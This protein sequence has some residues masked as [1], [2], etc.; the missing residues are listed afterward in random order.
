MPSMN[1]QPFSR[2]LVAES[3]V[4]L[5]GERRAK[6]LP[7]RIG[8]LPWVVDRNWLTI[9][10][11]STFRFDKSSTIN[12]VALEPVL[13]RPLHVGPTGKHENVML[14]DF[15]PLRLKVDFSV[16]GHI[17]N[18]P[19]PSGTASA[20]QQPRVV[21]IGLGERRLP[22][23]V[24][25]DKPGKIPLRPPYTRMLHGRDLDFALQ[26]CHDGSVHHFRHPADFD[27]S[28]YQCAIPELQYE[29]DEISSIRLEGLMPDPEVKM[30]LALPTYTPRALVTYRQANVQRGDV[31]FFL[32]TV[33][34]DLDESSVHVVWRGLAETAAN[35]YHDVDRIH[36]GWAPQSRWEADLRGCWDD[37]LRELPRGRF[38]WAV[39]RKD[40]LSDEPP[41]PLAE[42]E[43]LMARYATWGHPNAAEP[44]L[45]PHEAAAIAAELAEQRWPRAEVLARH[46]I[47]EYAW[48]IEERAWAQ[49]LASVGHEPDGGVSAEYAR[50]YQQASDALAT[51]RE[52]E[53][54]AAEF[55]TI[56]MRVKRG[57]PAKAFEEAGLGLGAYGRLERQFRA[58]ANED[59]AF[60]AE[61]ERLRTDE[62]I[63]LGDSTKIIRTGDSSS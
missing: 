16:Q 46:G 21:Q 25:V 4:R 12:P 42:E 24:S 50:A 26:R 49:R 39:E 33:L 5:P 30:E 54:T 14:D 27:L 22:F 36:I 29:V 56:E 32:D 8:I 62:E 9:F 31:R 19:L 1:I 3:P 41:P 28:V 34:V 59:K 35:P 7:C 23:V 60:A 61:L 55:V 38:S 48:G 13:P 51:P 37:N 58:K 57:N 11:S 6:P 44:E 52:K 53:I 17:D 45:L 20:F 2:I 15:V 40:V 43:L 10:I 63:K 47:D 18:P